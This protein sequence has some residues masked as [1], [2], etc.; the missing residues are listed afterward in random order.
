MK[1][2]GQKADISR[3]AATGQRFELADSVVRGLRLRVSAAGVKSWSLLYRAGGGFR[4][5]DLGLFPDVKLE[6][7]RTKAVTAKS[8]IRE[9]GADPQK[10]KAERRAQEKAAR[11]APRPETVAG[12]ALQCLA[13]LNLRPATR[14]EWTRLANKEL[15]TAFPNVLAT[16]LTRAEVKAWARTLAKRSGY[17]A[18]RA[19]S[20]LTRVYNWAASEEI[21]E[22]S[23]CVGVKK[24][25]Q[26]EESLERVLSASELR[27]IVQGLDALEE[28]AAMLRKE[29]ETEGPSA[30]YV[31]AAR[32]LLLTGVRRSAAVGAM[33]SEFEGL[34][35]LT[36]QWVVPGGG[37][38]RSKSGRAHVVP[39]SDP[40]LA[41]V[42]R[43]F[44]VTSGA[45]LFPVSRLKPEDRKALV[46]D[47]GRWRA[48]LEARRSDGQKKKD[49][50]MTWGSR[51]V[52]DLKRE[53]DR[54]YGSPLPPW[55]IHG[56]RASLATNSREVLRVSSD[57]VAAILGHTPPGAPVSRV[58]NRAELLDE[59]RAALVAW[60]AWLEQ[61]KAEPVKA[62][63]E[64]ST[65]ARVL[66]M[67]A[68]A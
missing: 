10:A 33:R 27:A 11:A 30:G 47:F 44:A 24:P 42:R 12:L 36:P 50:P 64:E 5:Y 19:L 49:R 39:L 37:A 45:Y 6:K 63:G 46:A 9:Q 53:A 3:I 14:K 21:V 40:A 34:D 67:R 59:K 65:G 31:D 61:I 55:K 23:P 20:F 4:R 25:F 60:A 66:P 62:G 7:A 57:V 54:I 35:T 15:A 17:V 38:G 68:R 43:R 16:D 52:R 51:F 32:L 58:Y 22:A 41:V 29:C 28:R 26:G 18:N 8:S 13:A 56:F 1:K 2:I 48:T